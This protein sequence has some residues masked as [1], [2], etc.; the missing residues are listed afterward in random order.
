MTDADFEHF[1]NEVE[2]TLANERV[3]LNQR[4]LTDSDSVQIAMN[5]FKKID[6]QGYG[7]IDRNMLRAYINRIL[8]YVAPTIPFNEASFETGFALLDRNSDNKITQDDLVYFTK[9]SRSK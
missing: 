4:N 2:S 7:Y 9:N 5:I 8:Q 1:E 3:M 6:V